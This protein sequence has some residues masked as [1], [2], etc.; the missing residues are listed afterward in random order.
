MLILRSILSIFLSDVKDTLQFFVFLP[1]K[2][3]RKSQYNKNAIKIGLVKKYKGGVLLAGGAKSGLRGKGVRALCQKKFR[4]HCI[5]GSQNFFKYF[6]EK[7]FRK[8]K[9]IPTENMRD[10]F[11]FKKSFFQVL[12]YM[13]KQFFVVINLP[14]L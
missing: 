12:T 10:N 6:A 8:I 5:R 9:V 2:I 13:Q 4:K 11:P 7:L 14:N 3:C 1:L